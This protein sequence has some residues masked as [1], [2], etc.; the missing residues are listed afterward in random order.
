MAASAGVEQNV[1][2]YS[3]N[4]RTELHPP[5]APDGDH[6]P[7]KTA[8]RVLAASK[9]CGACYHRRIG[10]FHPPPCSPAVFIAPPPHT[11]PSP[12]VSSIDTRKQTSRGCQAYKGHRYIPT[13][14]RMYIPLVLERAYEYLSKER[15]KRVSTY[16]CI[17]H[18]G[19]HPNRDHE[20]DT[21][22]SVLSLLSVSD[23]GFSAN[24]TRP[25]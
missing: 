20:F 23:N 15:K 22:L 10:P 6:H 2:S 3:C 16:V 9:R 19:S 5:N 21:F 13:Y 4:W 24:E 25:F 17:Q 14:I 1:A 8:G 12:Q 11:T 18:K 7:K